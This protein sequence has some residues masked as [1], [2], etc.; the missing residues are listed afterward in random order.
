M[1]TLPH[2]MRLAS[3]SSNLS[4]GVIVSSLDRETSSVNEHY[5]EM[6]YALLIL[7]P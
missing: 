1:L 7:S 4:D 5:S 6:S 2:L 3:D